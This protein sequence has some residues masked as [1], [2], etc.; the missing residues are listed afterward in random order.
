MP[1]PIPMG[2]AGDEPWGAG[3]SERTFFF[4]YHQWQT[5]QTPKNQRRA[6]HGISAGTRWPP[7]P[8]CWGWLPRLVFFG[9]SSNS[10]MKSDLKFGKEKAFRPE[11]GLFWSHRISF[12]FNWVINCF[13]RS[14]FRF[15]SGVSLP[16]LPGHMWVSWNSKESWPWSWGPSPES[17]YL[18]PTSPNTPRCLYREKISMFSQEKKVSKSGRQRKTKGAG[19]KKS[20]LF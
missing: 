9:M 12:S 15:F 11:K 19:P 6:P 10:C 17:L 14:P 4:L 1:H 20:I 16:W 2:W 3:N 18:L 13:L 8:P 5:P 7:R